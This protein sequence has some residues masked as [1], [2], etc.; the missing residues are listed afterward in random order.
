MVAG[1]WY[2]AYDG[3]TWDTPGDLDI[4][5]VVALSEAFQSGAH[6]WDVQRR[7]N[8]ANDLTD[9]RT[10]AAVTDNVNA[11]KGDRDPT[12]WLPSNA[13]ATCDYIGAWISIKVRWNLTIDPAEH[14]TLSN[15]L[16]EQC[17]GM[18]IDSISPPP[19]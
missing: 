5:H 8:Y 13:A 16:N 19:S 2:S 9:P 1:D 17:S 10:L 11:S 18:V 7:T 15:I 4:D 3:L 6:A 14:A 12:S